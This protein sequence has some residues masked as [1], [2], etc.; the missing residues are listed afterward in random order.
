MKKNFYLVGLLFLVT[1]TANS[2][3]NL[4]GI[5]ANFG[6]DA[7]TRSRYSK[8]GPSKDNVA[9]DWFAYAGGKGVI[10]TTDFAAYKAALQAGKNIAIMRNMSVPAYSIVNGKT[11]IDAIYL[12]DYSGYSG[13][14]STGFGTA[15]KNGEDPRDWDGKI[16]N[17]PTKTDII[18]AFAHV[19]RDGP[20]MNDSLWFY[21][22]VSTTATEGDRYFDIEL[23]KSHVGYNKLKGQ[24]SSDGT[25]NGHTEWLFDAFGNIIRTGDL[26]IAVSYSPGE[27]PKIEVRIWV[28][29]LTK[30]L[31]KPKLFK[32]SGSSDG[33]YL[34]CYA[35]IVSKTGGTAFGSGIGN[36]TDKGNELKD[37]TMSNPWGTSNR[38]GGWA[39]DYAQLQF[40]EIGL[41]FT[42]MG[43]DPASYG[44]STISCERV[45]HSI[46]FK[47]RSS[48]SF[49]AN[50][51]DHAGPIDFREA[52]GF[53]DLTITTDTLTC[54]KKTATLSAINPSGVGYFT[55]T[56]ANGSIVGKSDS[57]IITVDKPGTYYLNASLIAGCPSVVNQP[58]VVL[59][60]TE[61]PVANADITLTANGDIQLLGDV[62]IVNNLLNLNLNPN[63]FG[64]SKGLKYEWSGPNGFTSNEQNP[65]IEGAWA[66]GA[67]HLTVTELRNGC[68]SWAWM[69]VSF[70]KK[71]QEITEELQNVAV[72]SMNLTRKTSANKLLLT[73]NQPAD[74]SARVTVI[75]TAG[76]TVGNFNMKLAKGYNSYEMPLQAS[77]SARIVSVYVGNKL[78]MTRKI[79]F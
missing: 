72:G 15:A 7:D 11:W 39:Q 12:R 69:D 57:N 63:P 71:K 43:I 27:A 5:H 53:D 77:G 24:F 4:G 55:W 26:I 66:W 47:S 34:A 32:F 74:V 37:S 51:Q 50:L 49:S 58:V 1:L 35:T 41:N 22:G 70:D 65:V 28:S 40:V 68:K 42:R 45:F 30:T 20:T 14:D 56:T 29:L 8:L 61:K 52:L 19:R 59:A 6:I 48:S 16:V 23:F 79:M 44:L 31:I 9:D 13:K 64:P 46:F 73:T 17:V 33:G 62:Q 78:V 67:Y 2:Q 18:D 75:N 60:D 38:S 76:Q 25:S 3:L 36:F 54:A 10:D 21:A